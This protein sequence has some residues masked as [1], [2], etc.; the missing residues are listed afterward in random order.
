M[1]P[2]HAAGVEQAGAV[3]DD[4]TGTGIG[5]V[6]APDLRAVIEHS[7]VEAG[8]AACTV[9]QQQAGVLFGQAALQFVH[10]HHIA[11]VHFT[12][13]FC[14]QFGVVDV[15]QRAVHIPLEVFQRAAP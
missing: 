6:A 4:Q 3:L 2:H 10:T 11:V 7:A 12:L 1:R 15:C 14:R 5:V 13:L 9:F 8:T